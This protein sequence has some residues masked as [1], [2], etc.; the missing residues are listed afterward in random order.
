M[1]LHVNTCSRPDE[2][3]EVTFRRVLRGDDRAFRSLVE[4][5]QRPVFDLLF[6][7]LN[8]AP[9][10]SRKKAVG[11][12]RARGETAEDVTTIV[13]ASCADEPACE[14]SDPPA[15]CQK[16]RLDRTNITE[17]IARVRGRIATCG[18]RHPGT[19]QVRVKVAVS[20][21]GTVTAVTVTRAPTKALGACVATEVRQALFRP[22]KG[23]S[24]SYP[25]F[26]R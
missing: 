23:G 20:P 24:F 1:G 5:Y 15:C 9:D 3:D 26:F 16:E 17:G 25:F 22:S 21:E 18:D 7:I 2:L 10:S 8:R 14:G 12:S 6:R 19:G 13:E 11:A 4:R